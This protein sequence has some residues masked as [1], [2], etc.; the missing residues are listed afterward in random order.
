VP[1]APPL[2]KKAPTQMPTT[3][4]ILKNQNLK[5]HEMKDDTKLHSSNLNHSLSPS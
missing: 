4:R 5:Q 1:N 2:M 3:I